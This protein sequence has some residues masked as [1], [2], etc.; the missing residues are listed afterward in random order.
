MHTIHD[1]VLEFRKLLIAS[2]PIIERLNKQDPAEVFELNWTEAN[3]ELF[4]EGILNKGQDNIF[5]FPYDEG[6]DDMEYGYEDLGRCYPLSSRYFFPNQDPTHYVI[7][8]KKALTKGNNVNITDI[9]L[10]LAVI[11][12][13]IALK[14]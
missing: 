7:A 5:I 14:H 13:S 4:I 8:R 6:A 11:Y 3:W 2:Y 1:L 10:I 12:F 9:I